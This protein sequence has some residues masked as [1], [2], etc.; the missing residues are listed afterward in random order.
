VLS[1]TLSIHSPW[2]SSHDSNLLISWSHLVCLIPIRQPL[3]NPQF[4]FVWQRP[5]A[6]VWAR[7]LP[8]FT[9]Y[10]P[11]WPAICTPA[12]LFF[13]FMLFIYSI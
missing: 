5:W 2:S 3:I 11:P 8:L 7:L 9:V 10:T 6:P 13:L 12:F 4:F 1:C